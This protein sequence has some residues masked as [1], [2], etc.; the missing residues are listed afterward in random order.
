MSALF[1]DPPFYDPLIHTQSGYSEIDY[2]LIVQRIDD[3][4][5]LPSAERTAIRIPWR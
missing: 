5:L 2:G 4:V 3:N 1:I